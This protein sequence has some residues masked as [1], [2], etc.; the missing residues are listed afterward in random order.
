M[1]VEE[2]SITFGQVWKITPNTPSEETNS[3]TTDPAA[4][5]GTKFRFT[6]GV[7]GDPFFS[8]NNVTGTLSYVDAGG[9]N[10]SISGV[11]SRLV[12]T[13]SVVDGFYF[14]VQGSDGV[15]GTSDDSAY[16][17]KSGT[18]FVFAGSTAYNTSSDP[19]DRA[20]NAQILP[21]SAPT[22]AN[23]TGT[24]LEEGSTSGNVL[25]NDTDANQDPL[26][27]TSFT[28]NGVATPVTSTTPGSFVIP[29][30]GNL[31]MNSTGAYTFAPSANYAGQF[32]RLPMR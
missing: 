10:R 2:A 21:N 15:I 28:V 27:V 3:F 4:L 13:G 7:P 11:V 16:L 26:R 20:L 31:T 32:P 9:V 29:G 12:K 25:T 24:V 30:V 23:D 14:Y 5:A 1:N 8:G 19:V 22:L 6:S 18:S 17:F